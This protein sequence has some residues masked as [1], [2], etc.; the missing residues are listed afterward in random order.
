MQTGDFGAFVGLIQ[1]AIDVNPERYEAYDVLLSRIEEDGKLDKQTEFSPI[2]ASLNDTTDG[3]RV[4][5]ENVL[6]ASD[7]EGYAD[8]QFR[9]GKLL[10]LM[11]SGEDE[12]L[13]Q[14]ASYFKKALVNG[15]MA[16]ATDEETMKKAKLAHLLRLSASISALWDRVPPHLRKVSTP[17]PS[18][19][20]T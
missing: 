9:I 13:R 4:N 3:Y 10:F 2:T 15:E 19:G 7:I 14:A 20:R 6:L 11:S 16:N 18:F 8:I 5:N 17:T 1:D 12:N